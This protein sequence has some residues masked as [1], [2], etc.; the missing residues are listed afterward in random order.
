MKLIIKTSADGKNFIISPVEFSLS[1]IPGLS[2]YIE[3]LNGGYIEN[4]YIV[5]PLANTDTLELFHKIKKLFEDR[6]NYELISDSSSASLL[7]N[8]ENEEKKF[9]DFSYK[10]LSIR[11]NNI[12]KE[13]F[14][15]FISHLKCTNFKRNL[16]PYQLLSAYHLAFSQNACNF[17]VPGSGKTTTVLAAYSYLKNCQDM[18]KKVSKLI[19]IGPLSS[20]L[21]WKKEFYFCFKKKPNVLEIAG[22]TNTSKI[23]SSLIKTKVNEDIILVSYG[24]VF[25]REELLKIFMQSN[26]KFIL[27]FFHI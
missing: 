19:V 18:N 17:S 23:R 15:N 21:A 7:G 26:A 1:E 24:S 22:N 6:L 4:E 8:I 2:I 27:V 16:Q 10:A 13:E 5:I 20:F 3:N 25:R 12:N 14:N 9:K 11:N